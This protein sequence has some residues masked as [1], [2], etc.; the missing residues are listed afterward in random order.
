MPGSTAEQEV[1]WS[2]SFLV[3]WVGADVRERSAV[4][5]VLHFG[6]HRDQYPIRE[7]LTSHSYFKGV[8]DRSDHPFPYLLLLCDS[9]PES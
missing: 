8:L 7:Y 5:H 3:G 1:V 6:E 4:N 2:Q 9:Q